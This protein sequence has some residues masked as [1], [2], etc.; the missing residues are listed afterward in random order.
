[1]TFITGFENGQIIITCSEKGWWRTYWSPCTELSSLSTILLQILWSYF[2]FHSEGIQNIF[3]LYFIRKI[4]CNENFVTE[5]VKRL[6]YSY[7]QFL[8][9]KN[10]RNRSNLY[11]R[12]LLVHELRITHFIWHR[13]ST[14]KK[15]SVTSLFEGLIVV[16]TI[17]FNL[18]FDKIYI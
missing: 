10:Y 12:W 7:V 9:S 16:A 8:K 14:N 2:H 18:V 15:D 11:Y 6:L 17:L 3:F 1:M 4:L 5:L 13:V